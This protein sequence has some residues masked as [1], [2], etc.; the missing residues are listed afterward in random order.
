MRNG[1]ELLELNALWPAITVML[2]A[3]ALLFV[4]AV[5]LTAPL[6][7]RARGLVGVAIV[8]VVAGYTL[9]LADSPALVKLVPLT[10][11]II[12]GNFIPLICAMLAGTLFTDKA[13]P[14]WRR[15]PVAGILGILAVAA[16]LYP[17]AGR[18]VRTLNDVIEGVCIQTSEATCSP[19]AAV[20]VLLA[21]GIPAT[22]EDMTRLCLTTEEGTRLTG[23]YRGLRMKCAGT[24]FRVSVCKAD[25]E[26]LRTK[27][28]P[29]AILSVAL[30]KEISLREPKYK[31]KWGWTEGVAH[32]VVFLGFTNDTTVIV[33]D[34]SYGREPWNISGIQDL[35]TG[36]VVQLV[37]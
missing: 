7:G 24:P 8:L 4:V 9:L 19:A 2:L 30:S 35:W 25:L 11:V 1:I 22:E 20:T 3:S 16:I 10:N 37:R 12:Y 33:A 31:S 17:I 13:V 23:L 18:K 6:S 34:P 29:P 15:I 26:W 14:A 5:R 36:Q 28:I 27:A 21:H 32:S